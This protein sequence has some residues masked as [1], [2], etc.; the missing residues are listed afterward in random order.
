M[1]K[2]T[3]YEEIKTLTDEEFANLDV[4]LYTNEEIAQ[5]VKWYKEGLEELYQARVGHLI[6]EENPEPKD[7]LTEEEEKCSI[8]ELID[9]AKKKNF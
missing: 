1:K 4:D 5:L 3:S 2:I 6:T 7:E 9:K 8:Q